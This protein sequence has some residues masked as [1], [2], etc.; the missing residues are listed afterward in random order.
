MPPKSQSTSRTPSESSSRA[1]HARAAAA[2]APPHPPAPAPTPVLPVPVRG[3]APRALPVLN[4][5]NSS[6]Y[7]PNLQANLPRRL[8][9]DHDQSAPF[10]SAAPYRER[11]ANKC[12]GPSP[13][14]Q[15]KPLAE[16]TKFNRRRGNSPAYQLRNLRGA[17]KHNLQLNLQLQLKLKL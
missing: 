12:E 1:A 9:P 10:E 5:L 15:R 2:L 16:A 3:A 4:S 8:P 14:P 17:P 11:S 13:C 7:P 6:L